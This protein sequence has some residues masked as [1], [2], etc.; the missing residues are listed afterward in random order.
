MRPIRVLL[1]Y[2][3]FGALSF[4][5]IGLSLLKSQLLRAGIQCEIR[6]LNYD[7]LDQL[8]GDFLQRLSTFDGIS[9]RCS[10]VSARPLHISLRRASRSRFPGSMTRLS[11]GLTRRQESRSSRTSRPWE[12]SYRNSSGMPHLCRATS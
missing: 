8:P 5:S 9:R 1:I 12:S 6:Y 2:P 7:F 10:A 3:P 11:S 4:P